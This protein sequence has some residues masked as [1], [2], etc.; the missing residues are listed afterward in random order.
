M[1]DEG[2]R[3]LL[4]LA[5]NA[6]VAAS[7]RCVWRVLSDPATAARWL[8][9]F[10]GWISAP[11]LALTTLS[12]LRFRSRLHRVPVAAELRVL[13]VTPGRIRA[14]F[15]LGLFAFTARFSLVPEPGVEGATRI[16][17]VVSITNQIAVVSGS[18]D[19]FAVRKLASE[20]AE[21]TLA[22]ITACA[23]DLAQRAARP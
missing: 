10:E 16:G 13:E 11:P 9:S 6:K 23:E 7:P 22:A 14:Q 5:F 1:R 19:R 21:H 12:S 3:A 15:R 20:L 8:P 4:T 17:L 18:L 2:D